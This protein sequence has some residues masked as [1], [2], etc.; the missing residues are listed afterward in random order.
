MA[1]TQR[2]P[3]YPL[4]T[5]V[6]KH[7]TGYSDPFSGTVDKFIQ[8]SGFYHIS[9]DDGDSEEMTE[10][11]VETYFDRL[12]PS[13]G[14][15]PTTKRQQRLITSNAAAQA[16]NS[17]QKTPSTQ[18]SEADDGDDPSP[19][20]MNKLVGQRISKTYREASGEEKTMSGVVSCFFPAT[21]SYRVLLFNGTT[22]DMGYQDVVDSMPL[23]SPVVS[24]DGK[25][26]KSNGDLSGT[27]GPS[28]SPKRPKTFESDGRKM[29]SSMSDAVASSRGNGEQSNATTVNGTQSA[30]KDD[31][32]DSVNDTAGGLS[33][34]DGA[35]QEPFVWNKRKAYSTVRHV[36][37]IIASNSSV[38]CKQ[39]DQQ[40]Q[41]LGNAE[42]KPKRALEMFVEN[43]GLATLQELLSLWAPN[44]DTEQGILLVLKVLAVIP[45]VTK[46]AVM[47]SAIGRKLGDIRKGRDMNEPD[48]AIPDMAA[49][50]INKWKSSL[51]SAPPTSSD[52]DSKRKKKSS[53]GDSNDADNK[54]ESE[55]NSSKGAVATKLSARQSKSVSHL[56]D[57][58]SGRSARSTARGDLL[59]SALGVGR[60]SRPLG[61]AYAR[62]GKRS[63]VLLDS[64]AERQ[65]KNVEQEKAMLD[66]KETASVPDEWVGERVRFGDTS[67]LHF[68]K[69]IE[70]SYLLVRSS[71][72]DPKHKVVASKLPS[73]DKHP[74]KSILKV[75]LDA[76]ERVYVASEEHDNTEEGEDTTR[77]FSAVSE[78][79]GPR[80]RALPEEIL[81]GTDTIMQDA[82]SG[83]AP[84]NPP[85][86]P[87][88]RREAESFDTGNS[89]ATVTS[90]LSPSN[91]ETLQTLQVSSEGSVDTRPESH[92]NGTR[93]SPSFTEGPSSVVVPAPETSPWHVESPVV[94]P[95]ISSQESVG[96]IDGDHQFNAA[97]VAQAMTRSSPPPPPP[98]FSPPPPSE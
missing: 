60:K 27:D 3:R 25:K 64:I 10:D 42:L 23:C 74:T 1:R 65:V 85:S 16:G 98:P 20:E 62:K 89:D 58:M 9:Y 76:S 12:P 36:L 21:K 7:F 56:R 55:S 84:L 68:D 13:V 2:T 52:G 34:V 4:G 40:L 54:K 75:R 48:P 22:E 77:K 31:S 11:D 94:S 83:T 32:P 87:R 29:T 6:L 19:E 38:T 33:T 26:R 71:W 78:P 66:Q 81:Q 69:E 53:D 95:D 37:F 86:P 61:P 8:E 15:A 49:W 44:K 45:G 43:G 59:G 17:T 28:A 91:G 39:K 96:L 80:S 97:S 67:T 30:S 18:K 92:A 70:V 14:T 57:L 35:E 73:R 82:D 90:F 47:E 5:R 46:D 72:A 79:S 24:A 41:I 63:T 51:L 50:I 93:P 88:K